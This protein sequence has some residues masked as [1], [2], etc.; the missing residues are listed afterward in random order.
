MDAKNYIKNKSFCPLPWTGFIVHQNG[1]VRN[2]V[3]SKSK[4]GNLKDNSIQ[5]IV[6]GEKNKEI[7]RQMLSDAKPGNCEGCYRLEEN[8]NSFDIVSQRIYYLKELKTVDP[9]IYD[10]VDN[11]DL[12]TV[13]LRWS[14]QCNQACVYC[15]PHNSSM[16]AKEIGGEDLM[17]QEK[18]QRLKDYVFANVKQLKNV[19]L[20]GG[21]PLLMNENQEFLELLSKHNPGVTL[22]VNTNLSALETKVGKMIQTFKNVHWIVS[23]ESMGAAYDYI[24]YGGSWNKFCDNLS[25]LRK[26][27]EHKISFNML[28][29]VLNYIKL[30]DCVDYLR[31]QGFHENSFVIGPLYGPEYLNILNLPAP[32]I[33][34]AKKMLE[35]RI[36]SKP[37]YFLQDSYVNL[38]KYLDSPYEKN[39]Q[40]TFDGLARLDVRRKLESRK[41]FGEVYD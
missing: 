28:Y 22:R 4:I 5:E 3:L 40:G 2:C 35:H 29:F 24:R 18:K 17:D 21:E 25:E 30:F 6:S 1:D 16:W 8:K 36:E 41:I 39:M 14:N 15:G 27:K 38:L 20:A 10:S 12:H 37:G 19:Y 26:N 7:K 23:V 32:K 31:E 33:S 34:Q 13:D 9:I 11:F